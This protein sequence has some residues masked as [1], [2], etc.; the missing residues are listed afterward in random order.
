MSKINRNDEH[1]KI[2]SNIELLRVVLF[3]MVV[4]IHVTTYG[5]V[6]VTGGYEAESLSWF[7]ASFMRL[8]VAPA[9]IGFILITGFLMVNKNF[10]AR[11]YIK[12]LSIPF[13]IYFPVLLLFDYSTIYGDILSRITF[14]FNDVFSLVG[15]FYHL[16]YIVVLI[17]LALFIPYINKLLLYCSKK[18]HLQLVILLLVIS[19]INSTISLFSTHQ[20]FTGLLG[21]GSR[22]FLF[23]AIYVSGAYFGKHEIKIKKKTSLLGFITI[24]LFIFL[25]CVFYSKKTTLSYAEISSIFIV[26]QG[27]FLFLFFIKLEINNKFINNMGGLVYGGYIIHVFF[28]SFLQKFLPFTTFYN[29]RYYFLIDL[30]FIFLVVGLSLMT[31]FIRMRAYVILKPFFVSAINSICKK[32][33]NVSMA[34]SSID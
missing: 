6:L 3:L 5:L 26:L 10:E 34:E 12:K 17:I 2:K 21:V 33:N 27:I 19:T 25:Y 22:I 15:A 14:V 7:Y 20:F 16:W 4:S 31:E 32:I 28:I 29:D 23:I 9:V 1:M 13:L 24:P 30:F 18:Q 8:L 11:K